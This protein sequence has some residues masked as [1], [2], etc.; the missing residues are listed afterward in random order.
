MTLSAIYRYPVKGLGGEELSA[1]QPLERGLAGD[2]RWMFVDENGGFISQR[3]RT[4]LARFRAEL[5]GRDTLRILR[6]ADGEV[7]ADI[8]Q[9][10][11]GGAGAKTLSVT[12][13][14]D[15]FVATLIDFP[16]STRMAETLGI[17]G[18]R[19]VYMDRNNHRALD[20]RFARHAET[21]SFADGFPYLLTTTASLR[22]LSDRVGEELSM[23]RFR[24]NLVIDQPE[25]F[26]EDG[27]TEL[28]I[29]T[30]AFYT[31]KPCARCNVITHE[32]G[33]GDPAPEV[34]RALARYRKVGR[35]V[36]FGVNGVWSGGSG[37]LRVG[38]E[39]IHTRSAPLSARNPST[40]PGS[41]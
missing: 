23:L 33:T 12:V 14:E 9:P 4:Q 22:D 39:V 25:P 24:P 29:G 5:S 37:L 26:A 21:V 27:W 15:T 28:R 18:A 19:L 6:I 13:W 30:H 31:P 40:L 36:L 11:G 1:A 16:G 10:R 34:L 38:E 41:P 20:P 7:I 32:P 3:G 8:N 2:R 35:K 17:P